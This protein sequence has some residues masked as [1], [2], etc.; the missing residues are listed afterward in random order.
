[1]ARVT[2]ANRRTYFGAVC[3]MLL[4]SCVR[5]DH[6]SIHRGEGGGDYHAIAIE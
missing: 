6:R 3:L 2:E 4:N 1:M 5:L